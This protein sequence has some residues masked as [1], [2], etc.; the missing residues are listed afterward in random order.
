MIGYYNNPK[1]N[2]ESFFVLDGKR[3]FRTGDQ[4]RIVEKRVRNDL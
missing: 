4:G 1:A 2:E 3:Y